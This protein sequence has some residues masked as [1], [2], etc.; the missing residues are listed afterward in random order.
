MPVFDATVARRAL[1]SGACVVVVGA[2]KA[3]VAVAVAV[4]V[5]ADPC[6]R[7]VASGGGASEVRLALLTDAASSA[8]AEGVAVPV[9]GA[10][11][12]YMSL[13]SGLSQSSPCTRCCD[14]GLGEREPVPVRS[15]GPMPLICAG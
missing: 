3:D 13:R 2:V 11:Q 1:A 15:S 5:D 14:A 7:S 10:P 12:L 6:T 4:A 8:R 9:S